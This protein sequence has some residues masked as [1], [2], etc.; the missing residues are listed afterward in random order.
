MC[1]IAG[2]WRTSGHTKN[3]DNSDVRAMIKAIAHRGPDG[4][5]FWS[6]ERLALGH[7]RLAILDPSDRGLQPAITPDQTGVLAYNGEIYNYRELRRELEQCGIQFLSATDTEVVLW[8]L[9]HW[10]VEKAIR[11]FSGMFSFAYFDQRSNALWLCRDRL[12]IK[13]LSIAKTGDRIIFASED[14]AILKASGFECRLDARSLT[15]SLALQNI[16]SHLSSFAGI[17]RL[18]PGACWRIDGAR[19]EEDCFWDALTAVDFLRLGDRT[20]SVEEAAKELETLLR[21]SIQLHCVA[22]VDMATACSSGVDSGL[23]TA[24][25]R[26]FSNPFHAYVV[27]PDC[28]ISEVAG[29]RRTCEQSGVP[30]REVNIDRESYLRNLTTAIYHVENGNLS[31]STAA[32]LAMTNRCK[33]DGIKVLLTGEGAD[34]LFGGYEWHAISGK[35]ARLKSFLAALAPTRKARERH[36]GRLT[37]AA[38]ANVLAASSSVGR[39]IDST[40]LFARNNLYSEE[41]LETLQPLSPVFARTFAGNGIF[42]LYSHMQGIIHRHDRISMASSVELRVPF[43]EN[44]VIDFALNLHPDFKY[45][46]KQGKWLLKEVASKYLPRENILARKK[47]FP[48]TSEYLEGSQELLKGG[49][50]SEFFGWSSR[51]TFRIS[52]MCKVDASLRARVV[53][54]EI[55]IRIYGH[56]ASAE[57]LGE[58]LVALSLLTK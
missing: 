54:Q 17:R 6:S 41:I 56:G 39:R 31:N 30:L 55:F 46:K 23:I 47:G 13:S 32:L 20:K 51:E 21:R 35:R 57:E 49:A 7:C 11:R 18:P 48:V 25:S 44:A 5:G 12:G 27:A 9:H 22:D 14:K 1:G 10:G 28:G 3:C 2:I 38:F 19:I 53:G 4:Q 37:G 36:A 42:D 26:N 8:A 33:S 34:E 16:D 52:E 45:R 40:S 58:K 15:L 29:A 43:L 24:V 50:L